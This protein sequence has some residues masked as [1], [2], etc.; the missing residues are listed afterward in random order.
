MECSLEGDV[1][2]LSFLSLFPGEHSTSSISC[3]HDALHTTGRRQGQMAGTTTSEGKS[4]NTSFLLKNQLSQE[5]CH[6][7]GKLTCPLSDM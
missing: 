2:A 1:G 6:S 5:F 7:D 4:Q 3:W